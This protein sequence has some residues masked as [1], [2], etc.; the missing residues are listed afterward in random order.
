MG[1]L[2]TLTGVLHVVKREAIQLIQ[3]LYNID[4][5]T[6]SVPNVK[7]KVSTALTPIYDRIHHFVMRHEFCTHFDET[8]SRDRGKRHFVWLATCQQAA[9]YRIDRN[10][11]TAAFKRLIG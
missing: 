11:S 5:G 1:L 6:G 7:E 4:M 8:G 2:A 9:V 10:R 3:D